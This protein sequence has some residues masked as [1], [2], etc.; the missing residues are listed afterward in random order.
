MTDPNKLFGR[1]G[2]RMFQMA[3]ILSQL[4]KGNISDIYLQDPKYFKNNE[5]LIKSYFSEGIVSVPFV[6]IHVRR[7]DYVDNPFYVDLTKVDYY[8]KAIALF[9]GEM[10]LVF[11]DD[12]EFCKTLS[13]FHPR[14][15]KIVEKGNEVE[16]LNKIASCHHNIIA[17]SS[18]SWWAAYLNP[19]EDKKIVAPSKDWWYSDGIERTIC[20]NEWTR[21]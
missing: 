12:P 6:S 17:N 18:Y 4:G 5:N 9:P 19:H 2:N 14:Y 3:Y 15:M 10:F 11:S 16:D 21:I 1:L 8:E 20:P 13:W 7:G